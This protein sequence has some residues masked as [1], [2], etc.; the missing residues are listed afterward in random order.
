VTGSR[1]ATAEAVVATAAAAGATLVCAGFSFACAVVA[2][3]GVKCWGNYSSAG[4]TGVSTTPID[5]PNISGAVSVGCG[6]SHACVLTTSGG[7]KCWGRNAAGQLGHSAKGAG[8]FGVADVTGLT[9][10]VRAIAVR[11]DSTCALM[12]N[13]GVKCW[14]N[15][16]DGQLGNGTPFGY[17]NG[18]VTPVDVTGIG[19]ESNAR[20]IATGYAACAVLPGGV[21][22]WGANQEREL[23]NN[24]NVEH[25]NTPV[26]VANLATG[27]TAISTDHHGC[28]AVGLEVKCWGANGFG[29]VGLGSAG[30]NVPTPAAVVGL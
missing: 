27:V 23:G 7:V 18:S 29:Q 11:I 24:S 15:N 12:N 9:S 19:A 22:C 3:G 8:D 4:F 2:G 14:G 16:N 5:V 1:L 20:A 21:K 6:T 28:A 17:E 13:G 10:G 30:G 25:V 26:D